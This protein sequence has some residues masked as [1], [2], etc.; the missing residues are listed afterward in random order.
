MTDKDLIYNCFDPKHEVSIQGLFEA[1]FSRKMSSA[2]WRWRFLNNPHGAA[3]IDLAWDKELLVGHYAVSKCRLKMGDREFL[4]G[5]SGTTMTHPS[6]RGLGLFPKLAEKTY[7]RMSKDGL[8]GVWGFPN[9]NSHRGFVRDLKWM[10]IYEIPTFRLRLSGSA[11]V[12]GDIDGVSEVSIIDES[13]DDLWARANLSHKLLVKRDASYLRWRYFANLEGKYRAMVLS[14]NGKLLGYAIFKRYENEIQIVDMLTMPDISI[15]KRL[16]Q[17]SINVAVKEGCSA[18]SMW[19]NV[20]DPLHHTLEQIGFRDDAP[21]TYFGGR[22]FDES[23]GN[24]F[25]DYKNWHITMGDS[26]VY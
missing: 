8:V 6:Y 5:L 10:D 13:F 26:D 12:A 7:A 9:V 20:N 4:S 3:I 17:Q 21:I 22:V 2:V 11:T 14:E 15:G 23:Q 24:I 25:Y 1:S 18:V 19:L 16:V